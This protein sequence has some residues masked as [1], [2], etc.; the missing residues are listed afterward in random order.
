MNEEI[1]KRRLQS[2]EAGIGTLKATVKGQQEQI[3]FLQE[4]VSTSHETISSLRL[5]IRDLERKQEEEDF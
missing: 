3:T 2:L 1:L 5:R 4:Q